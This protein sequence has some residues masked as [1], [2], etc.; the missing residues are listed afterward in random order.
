MTLGQQRHTSGTF[1]VKPHIQQC[2]LNSVLQ[3]YST[4]SCI[5]LGC[6]LSHCLA[7]LLLHHAR[8]SPMIF[9][10][11]SVW[12]SNTM[13]STAGFT[14]IHPLCISTNNCRSRTTHDSCSFGNTCSEPSS[15]PSIKV[16]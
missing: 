4:W 11:D 2:P 7:P 10:F 9:F 12:T 14:V 5:V 16:A 1:A 6:Q 15:L 3:Y 8:Q 13:S